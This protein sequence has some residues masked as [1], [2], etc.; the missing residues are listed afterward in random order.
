M[1]KP[2]GWITRPFKIT[3]ACCCLLGCALPPAL[4][5]RQNPPGKPWI[6][7]T[8]SGVVANWLSPDNWLT[9]EVKVARPGA[10]DVG[11]ILKAIGWGETPSGGHRVALTAGGETLR[12]LLENLEPVA[13]VRA[14]VF[15]EA[16]ARLGRVRITSS[17]KCTITLKAEEIVGGGSGLTVAGVFLTVC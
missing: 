17:G 14:R 5:Q 12:G 8:N 2:Q 11:I 13:D 1:M 9:W 6:W 4:A 3:I 10:F 16:I 7:L 15:P